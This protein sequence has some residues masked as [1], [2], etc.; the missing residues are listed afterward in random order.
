[1]CLWCVLG[2]GWGRRSLHELSSDI[3]FNE[4][5]LGNVIKQAYRELFNISET[6]FKEVYIN[7]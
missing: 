1:M 3:K 7:C 5:S 6:N 4:K 2:R